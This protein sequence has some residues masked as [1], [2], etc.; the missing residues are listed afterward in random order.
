MR[1]GLDLDLQSEQLAHPHE[2]RF[3]VCTGGRF[4]GNLR[5]PRKAEHLPTIGSIPLQ[6]LAPPRNDLDVVRIR[7]RAASG[8]A[9]AENAIA[10][11]DD[12]AVDERWIAPPFKGDDLDG[13]ESLGGIWRLQLTLIAKLHC[14]SKY[15]RIALSRLSNFVTRQQ[16]AVIRQ[17]SLDGIHL[18]ILDT[19]VQPDAANR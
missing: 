8:S 5:L 1:A 2:S 19:R 12:G 9:A 16:S 14:R 7:R 10:P 4:I 13:R 3:N 17:H 6:N 18:R 15:R 11:D